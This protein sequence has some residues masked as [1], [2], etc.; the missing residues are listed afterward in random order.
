M[1]HASHTGHH[2]QTSASMYMCL[3]NMVGQS[4]SHASFHKQMT[5]VFIKTRRTL[6]KMCTMAMCIQC[7]NIVQLGWSFHVLL[8]TTPTTV[9]PRWLGKYLKDTEPG[10]HINTGVGH[11]QRKKCKMLQT[12]FDFL[13]AHTGWTAAWNERVS[14]T[15]G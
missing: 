5:S 13:S 15:G 6:L 2:S 7:K 1:L 4:S 10:L 12:N 8:S 3:T 11:L 9:M 14:W